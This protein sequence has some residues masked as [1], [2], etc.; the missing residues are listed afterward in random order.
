MNNTEKLVTLKTLFKDFECHKNDDEFVVLFSISRSSIKRF[1]ECQENEIQFGSY[2]VNELYVDINDLPAKEGQTAKASI[3]A[4]QLKAQGLNVYWDWEDLLAYKPNITAVPDNF[5]IIDEEIVYPVEPASNKTKHYKEICTLLNLLISNADH[6]N[7]LTSKIINDV[8][9]LHK[10]RLEIPIAYNQECL[11]E[12]LDGI[13]IIVA[14]F[15]DQSHIEQKSSIL[16]ETLYSLLINVSKKDRLQYLLNNFGDFSKRLN[17]NYQLFVS[18]FSFDDVRKEYE[19]KKRDYLT[20]LNEVFS[21][22]QTKMLGIPIALALASL[23]L[24]AIVD[25]ITF[26]TNF[27]L[28]LSITIYSV[29][30]FM[31]ITNQKHTLNALKNEYESQMARLK[32]QYADQYEQVKEIL[33]DLNLRYDHQNNCLSWFYAMTA[34]LFILVLALFFWNLPWKLILGI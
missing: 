26:W 20:K 17:E 11:G 32:H 12:G 5:L 6:T 34:A 18:E 1:V 14:L 15:K 3:S 28:A 22:A 30:M 19:E 10:T 13:S 21:S 23:K 2:L 4:Q 7:N 29:M 16:K 27:F 24:S 9:F 8:V 25:N 31:L 33:T